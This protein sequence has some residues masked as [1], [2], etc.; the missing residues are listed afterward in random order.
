[1]AKHEASKMV[2]LKGH[3]GRRGLVGILARPADFP[4]GVE[5]TVFYTHLGSDWGQEQFDFDVVSVSYIKADRTWWLAGKRGEIVEIGDDVSITKIPTADTGPGE[6]YGYLSEIRLIGE[7]LF[8]CGYRRQVYAKDGKNWMLISKEIIDSR[9]KGPWVGF[10]SIDGFT[11][12]D[13]YAVGD[14]GE[15]WQYNGHDWH[16]CAS[17]TNA[18]LSCVRRID[19]EM[20]ACGDKGTVL[21]LVSGAWS[22]VCCDEGPSAAWW[23]IEG[24]DGKVYVAGDDFL[25]VVDGDQ[26]IQVS[27]N[28]PPSTASLSESEGVLW[29]VGERHIFSHDGK[30]WKE[31]VAPENA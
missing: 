17:P 20:W 18:N 19:N 8:V 13:L 29:S 3:S 26:V 9:K 14:E 5:A 22:V 21:R 15:I 30:K 27:T 1:M 31:H 28:I 10:E 23:S 7:Q 12:E 11:P 25:G 4:P 16:P 24:H 6:K 2:Y